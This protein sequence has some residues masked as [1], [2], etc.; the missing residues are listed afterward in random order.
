M[1]IFFCLSF[2]L[3]IFYVNCA[4]RK[5]THLWS[6]ANEVIAY[7]SFI[8]LLLQVLTFLAI[9]YFVCWTWTHAAH[10]F[11]STAKKKT[12]KK[13]S[14]I[15]FLVENCKWMN[16]IDAHNG[17]AFSHGKFQDNFLYKIFIVVIATVISIFNRSISF[18][19]NQMKKISI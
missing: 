1:H 17:V 16:W 15:K 18:Q 6:S 10:T 9:P 14:R 3:S 19:I 8:W 7:Y 11:N 13:S 5:Y 12:N 4:L 2:I